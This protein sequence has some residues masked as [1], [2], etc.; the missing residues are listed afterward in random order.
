MSFMAVAFL[1]QGVLDREVW[2]RS[3]LALLLTLCS[4]GEI[5]LRSERARS[6]ASRQR[7]CD[8]RQREPGCLPAPL[9]PSPPEGGPVIKAYLD[10][11]SNFS[12]QNTTVLL[13]PG[14]RSLALAILDPEKLPQPFSC[15]MVR[16]AKPSSTSLVT[17]RTTV[18]LS[19]PMPSRIRLLQITIALRRRRIRLGSHAGPTRTHGGL[20]QRAYRILR[21][22]A[23]NENP[24]A[25]AKALQVAVP[26]YMAS[27][28]VAKCNLQDPRTSSI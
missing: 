16:A 9:P 4:L 27:C 8:K 10:R 1:L 21:G 24:V 14:R 19:S 11:P 25:Y 17:I 5:V 28:M 13:L 3:T 12:E 15:V 7:N 22:D 18:Q 6:R 23:T 20:R 26:P 2:S